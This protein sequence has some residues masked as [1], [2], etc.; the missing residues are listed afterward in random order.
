MSPGTRTFCTPERFARAF[1]I[2]LTRSTERRRGM[3]WHGMQKDEIVF[4]NCLICEYSYL[5]MRTI[6]GWGILFCH[7][8][9]AACNTEST[10][11]YIAQHSTPA[12]HATHTHVEKQPGTLARTIDES[13]AA[14]SVLCPWIYER[15]RTGAK[16]KIDKS[17]GSRGVEASLLVYACRLVMLRKLLLRL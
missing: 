14:D 4:R 1:T 12:T 2:I 10:V 3:A 16:Y 15:R 9:A 17:T 5:L 8:A 7:L 6:R 11:G 13:C